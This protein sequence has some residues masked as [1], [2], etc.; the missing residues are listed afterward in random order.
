MA[1]LGLKNLNSSY[2]Y[3]DNVK[4]IYTILVN[5]IVVISKLLCKFVKDYH[6][7]NIYDN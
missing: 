5:I 7:I 4:I 6:Q 2:K 3:D 1:S